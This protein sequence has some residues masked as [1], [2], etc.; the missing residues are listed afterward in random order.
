MATKTKKNFTNAWLEKINEAKDSAVKSSRGKTITNQYPR[1][2]ELT[3]VARKTTPK[4]ATRP[5]DPPKQTKAKAKANSAQVRRVN[6]LQLPVVPVV[7]VNMNLGTTEMLTQ[8]R[9][10]PQAR[11]NQILE[12]LRVNDY[13]A[14]QRAYSLLTYGT[15]PID[16]LLKKAETIA[17]QAHANQFRKNGYTPYITHVE[18]VVRGCVYNDDKIAA[19]LHDVV[20]DGKVSLEFLRKHFATHIVNAVDALTHRQGESYNAY[21]RRA[22]AN[23]I[24]RRVKLQDLAHNMNDGIDRTSDKYEKYSFAR[25][26]LL[27]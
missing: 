7:Q 21:I 16:F 20:E 24:A 10:L 1:Y 8:L 4:L 13:A 11:K 19:W 15:E 3:N 9:A 12:H 17:R 5:L 23:E 2:G 22:K 25:D 14:Y 18:T 26:I 6:P 27:S